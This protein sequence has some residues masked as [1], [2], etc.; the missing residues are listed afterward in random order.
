[1]NLDQSLVT[2]K[3]D[4]I[5]PTFHQVFSIE[6]GS[7]PSQ[8]IFVSSDSPWSEG[9]PPVSMIQEGDPLTPVST[10]P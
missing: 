1:M 10:V 2:K 8:F 7:H 4:L 9:D 5:S 6:S 3:V